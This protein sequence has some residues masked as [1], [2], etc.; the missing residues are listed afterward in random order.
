M[1]RKEEKQP[2]LNTKF[3]I[4]LIKKDIPPVEVPGLYEQLM[5]VKFSVYDMSNF[6][7]DDLKESIGQF[8]YKQK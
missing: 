2:N 8:L 1:E 5:S 3:K 4:R 6:N 7:L